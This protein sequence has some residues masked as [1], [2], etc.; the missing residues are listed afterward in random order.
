[1]RVVAAVLLVLLLAETL[2]GTVGPATGASQSGLGAFLQTSDPSPTASS[3]VVVKAFNSYCVN[4]KACQFTIFLTNKDQYN[5]MVVAW[6]C[7]SSVA[8]RIND[9]L[10]NSWGSLDV[11]LSVRDFG[12]GVAHTVETSIPQSDTFTVACKEKSPIITIQ[13][14]EVKGLGS[15][16]AVNTARG[17]CTFLCN[18]TLSTS[19]SISLPPPGNY[20][21]V[22][23]AYASPGCNCTLSGTGYNLNIVYADFFQSTEYSTSLQASTNFPMTDLA[24]PLE[25]IDGGVAF[26]RLG[27]PSVGVSPLAIEAGQGASLLINTPFTGGTPPFTCQWLAEAP[28]ATFGPLGS[29]FACAAGTT[30]SFPTGALKTLGTWSFELMVNDSSPT[31]LSVTSAPTKLVVGSVAVSLVCSP[32]A[33]RVGGTTICK[34]KVV[35][36]SV[37]GLVSWSSSSSGKFSTPLCRLAGGSCMVR[38]TPSSSAP[39]TTIRADYLGVSGL[40]IAA[41]MVRLKV[42]KATTSTVVSCSPKTSF[43]GVGT[44]WRC[45][46]MISGFSP[47]GHVTW[48]EMGGTGMVQFVSSTCYA[49]RGRCSITLKAVVTGSVVMLAQYGGDRNNGPSAGFRTFTVRAP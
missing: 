47:T 38:F 24:T 40:T 49:S 7:A 48:L 34:A 32:P 23:V 5:L 12:V 33:F 22:G 37:T 46:A 31:P 9:S 45:T 4:S 20:F 41:G 19:S 26:I 16:F 21:A 6:G 15:T 2:S 13:Y 25:W 29:P 1:M 17:V 44:T 35:G 27:A 36:A 43:G 14:E 11:N 8:T 28:K 39:S 42:T 3:A 30:P 18:S 10:F